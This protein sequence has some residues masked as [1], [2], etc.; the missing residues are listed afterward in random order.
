MRW[1]LMSTKLRGQLGPKTEPSCIVAPLPAD[2]TGLAQLYPRD[3]QFGPQEESLFRYTDCRRFLQQGSAEGT[4]A[5][6]QS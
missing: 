2:R 4:I 5:D 3:S 1:L 6:R